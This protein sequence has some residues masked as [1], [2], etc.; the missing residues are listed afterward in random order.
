MFTFGKPRKQ[1]I[2]NKSLNDYCM[3]STQESI[4]KIIEK[5]NL[6]RNKENINNILDDNDENK[7]PELN[8]YS[9]FIFLSISSIG[10]ILYKRLN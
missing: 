4:K 7:K 2:I 8:L 6:E 1:L 9:F 3:K 10:F 5:S